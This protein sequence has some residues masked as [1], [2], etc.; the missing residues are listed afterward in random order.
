VISARDPWRSPAWEALAAG[1]NLLYT[2]LYIQGEPVA[3]AAAFSGALLYNRICRSHGLLAESALWL[4]Y[5]LVAIGGAVHWFWQGWDSTPEPPAGWRDIY[6]LPL[7][8]GC[9]VLWWI[10]ARYLR[11]RTHA[12]SPVL[13]AF[14]TVFSIPATLLMMAWI[15]SQWYYWLV[16]NAVSIGLYLRHRLWAGALMYL[17]Y[18]GLGAWGL[19]RYLAGA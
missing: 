10:T 7:L 2:Y 19:W 16:I 13:D 1:L 8:S 5:A 18:W 6:H 17:L 11:R 15:P 12:L 9:I 3:F 4:F 14:T